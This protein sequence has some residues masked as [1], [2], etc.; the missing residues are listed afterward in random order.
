MA[1]SSPTT[2]TADNTQLEASDH[3]MGAIMLSIVDIQQIDENPQYGLQ[4]CPK[5]PIKYNGV[6]PEYF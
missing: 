6:N 5:I 2:Y 3:K 4:A 1:L